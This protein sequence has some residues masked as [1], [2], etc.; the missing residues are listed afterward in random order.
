MY[1]AQARLFSLDELLDLY[2]K[3]LILDWRSKTSGL[4]LSVRNELDLLQLS[5]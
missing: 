1:T 3:I 5:M 2:R 4:N